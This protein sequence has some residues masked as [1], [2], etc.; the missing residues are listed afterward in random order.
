[1][2]AALMCLALM[3]PTLQHPQ[4]SSTYLRLWAK[5]IMTLICQGYPLALRPDTVQGSIRST[6]QDVQLWL[7]TWNA[8][9]PARKSP[10]LQP[11]VEV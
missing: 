4:E 2:P 1:M 3:Q 9:I 7:Q 10:E 11:R 5:I 8:C 6:L